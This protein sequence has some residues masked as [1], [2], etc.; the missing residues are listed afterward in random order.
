M[1]D[2]KM[3][4]SSSDLAAASI[5][6]S[7]LNEHEIPARVMD[8]KDSAFVFIGKAEVFVP[9]VWEEKA[10]A[11]IADINLDSIQA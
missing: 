10:L 4:F 1:Q 3:I 2:W 11:L 5:V 6:S 9:V 8:K 7:I